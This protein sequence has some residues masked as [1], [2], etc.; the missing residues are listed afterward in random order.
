MLKVKNV[1][2]DSFVLT[3]SSILK[4]IMSQ[5]IPEIDLLVRESLQNSLD[6]VKENANFVKVV[7][8]TGQ[9]ESTA[10][11]DY[12]EDVGE[13]LKNVIA[14]KMSNY[15]AIKDSNTKGLLG[16][17]IYRKGCDNNLYSLV[18]DIMSTS[19]DSGSG[20]SWGI[21]KSVYYRFGNGICFYYSRTFENGQ[22]LNKFV[23]TIIEREDK[24]NRLT[25]N[26]TGIAFFGD[27]DS[28]GK[29][30]PI[31]DEV[32]IN[33]ILNIFKIEPFKNDETGTIVIIP[34]VDYERLLSNQINQD[35]YWSNSINDCL[36][37]TIQRWYFSRLN[38]LEYP[39]G[40]FLIACVN[41]DRVEL[42]DF[43]QKLQ[44]MYNKKDEKATYVPVRHQF[45]PDDLG[46]LI[47]RKFTKQEFIPKIGPFISPYAYFDIEYDESTNKAVL[48]YMRGPG[49]V[50]SYNSNEFNTI[51]TGKEEYLIGFFVLNDL[52]KLENEYLGEYFRNTEQAS[53][54]NW[55]NMNFENFPLFSSKKPYTKI[56]KFVDKE[57]DKVFGMTNELIEDTSSMI[58][59]KKLGKLLLPPEDFN[60]GVSVDKKSNGKGSKKKV[61]KQNIKFIGFDNNELMFGLSLNMKPGD[62]VRF[63][64][65]IYANGK[66]SFD[67]WNNMGFNLPVEFDYFSIKSLSFGKV[68]KNDLN[69]VMYFNNM[70]AKSISYNGEKVFMYSPIKDSAGNCCGV[71]IKN[72]REEDVSFRFLIAIKPIDLAYSIV[73]DTDWKQSKGGVIS[74]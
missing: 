26:D 63:Y 32:E 17:H 12:L 4:L 38:N 33:K 48:F 14:S 56:I 53:H 34:Y 44:D 74:E 66:Y 28:N 35:N 36:N 40:K 27:I 52:C 29:S 24:I 70:V 37:I 61:A 42:N 2:K 16:T 6:A 5:G 68:Q 1:I 46:I 19:K 41:D 25:N 51:L 13:N 72:S 10:I 15:I 60:N 22:Y 31:Y 7:Y 71:S 57:F 30:T 59:Q 69:Y 55:A 9:F 54:Y 49:M 64:A 45:F 39:T 11:C 58:L 18:Y 23:G 47:Y 20:G 65:S 8:M 73:I 50:L 62:L 67:E 3:G 21:G 43:F